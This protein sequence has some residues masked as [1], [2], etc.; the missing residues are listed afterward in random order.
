MFWTRKYITCNRTAFLYFLFAKYSR[1]FIVMNSRGLETWWVGEGWLGRWEQPGR[2]RRWL[3][4]KNWA[5]SWWAGIGL[6]INS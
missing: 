4:G 3:G 1:N 6:L 2:V 5:G